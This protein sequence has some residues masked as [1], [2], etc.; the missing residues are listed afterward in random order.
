MTRR[1]VPAV[2]L[3]RWIAVAG[4]AYVALYAAAFAMGIE[5]GPTDREIREYYADG[6]HRAREVVAFFLIVA[7]ALAFVLFALGLRALVF[8]A[9]GPGT[10]SALVFTGGVLY[11]ALVL[12]GNALSRATAFSAMDADFELEPNTRRLFESAGFLA[13]A[14]GAM[15]AGLLV[16]GVSLAARRSGVLPRPLAW[17][18]FAAAALL[19]LAIAFVGFLVLALWV[20]V[21]SVVLALRR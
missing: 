11:G 4:L 1:W 2:R 17:F 7:A 16:V 3:E 6:G 19:P 20:V 8:R 9:A 14:S 18:G 10:V 5:V 13:F 15:A 21:V 12:V